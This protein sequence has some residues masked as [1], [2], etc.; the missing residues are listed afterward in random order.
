MQQRMLLAALGD[1]LGRMTS[2]ALASECLFDALL[3]PGGAMPTNAA[4]CPVFVRDVLAGVLCARLGP[5]GAA[6]I[7]AALCTVRWESELARPS[8]LHQG[9]V[10][11]VVVLAGSS[12]VAEALAALVYPCRLDAETASTGEA[13]RIALQVAPRSIVADVAEPPSLGGR[14]L[15]DLLQLEAPGVPVGLACG[16]TPYGQALWTALVE[17]PDRPVTWLGAP[18]RLSRR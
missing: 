11:R 15:A 18:Q 17:Q 10:P 3:G 5:S 6:R 8:A 1:V 7:V 14:E 12:R 2:P 4:D 9:A 16:P 13:C